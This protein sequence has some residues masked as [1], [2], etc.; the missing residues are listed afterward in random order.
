MMSSLAIRL[1]SYK[2]DELARPHR[3]ELEAEN[4]HSC[5]KRRMNPDLRH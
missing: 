3:Y 2:L 4:K 5:A 1:M